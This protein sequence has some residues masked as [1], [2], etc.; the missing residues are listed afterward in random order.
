M[1]VLA[2]ISK[3]FFR[4]IKKVAKLTETAFTDTLWFMM[5]KNLHFELITVTDYFN[6][7]T[8]HH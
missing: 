3:E 6:S 8:V 4:R 5:Y 1:L 7:E 2:K